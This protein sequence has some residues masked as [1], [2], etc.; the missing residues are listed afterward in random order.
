M[1]HSAALRMDAGGTEIR[2]ALS[3]GIDLI[4]TEIDNLSTLIAELRP[5]A[6]DEIGLVPALRNLADRKGREG[7]IGVDVLSRLDED[8]RF[9]PETESML[10]RLA[11][12]AL[13]NVVKHARASHVEV[14]LERTDDVV[15]ISIHDDGDGFD[16]S[17]ASSGFGLI[18]MRER[19]KLV[20]GELQISAVTGRGTTGSAIIPLRTT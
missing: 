2:Q 12:E 11:Q 15:N 9:P 16:V 19:V 18:G 6:L 3:D 1:L 17:A 7:G 8:G 13:T 14:I 4:D 10:Y 5:A 20:D